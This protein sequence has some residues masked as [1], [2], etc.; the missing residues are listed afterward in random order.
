MRPRKTATAENLAET[1]TS[2]KSHFD[3]P[4]PKS[5][6][7][8][9]AL[10]YELTR[11]SGESLFHQL[12]AL[13]VMRNDRYVTVT[14]ESD[15][16]NDTT[17]VKR[18]RGRPRKNPL[19]TPTPAVVT[20]STSRYQKVPHTIESLTSNLLGA[21]AEAINSVLRGSGSQSDPRK[22][23]QKCLASADLKKRIETSL[24]ELVELGIAVEVE[25]PA[26]LGRGLAIT[27]TGITIV[28]QVMVKT[29]GTTYGVHS[30]AKN[31]LEAGLKLQ[32]FLPTT[33][34]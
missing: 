23:K 19:P 18:K 30:M 1:D 4:V 16:N 21:S 34:V 7:A 20:E 28:R 15:Q 9:R 24:E 29:G 5:N 8:D 13:G 33:Q 11:L 12:Y 31:H 25:A 2:E 26:G 17:I 6:K 14:I 27:E 10:E 3:I 22:I 32:S